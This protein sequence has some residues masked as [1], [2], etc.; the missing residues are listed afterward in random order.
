MKTLSAI[1]CA[2]AFLLS[3]GCQGI[4]PFSTSSAAP[5]PS[6][7]PAPKFEL[8]LGPPDTSFKS[9]FGFVDQRSNTQVWIKADIY[10]VLLRDSKAK[11]IDWTKKQDQGKALSSVPVSGLVAVESG[12]QAKSF[13]IDA[14][15]AKKGL[16]DYL[17]QQGATSLANSSTVYTI[18]GMIAPIST[19]D[20]TG[21]LVALTCST[22]GR[23]ITPGRRE[24]SFNFAV[25]PKVVN[26]SKVFI[27]ATAAQSLSASE[28][29][30]CD[31]KNEP[32]DLVQL[33]KSVVYGSSFYLG[34]K[35]ALVISGIHDSETDN[36]NT[37][38]VMVLTAGIVKPE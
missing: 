33:R 16:S 5:T 20:A 7:V 32:K 19:I 3:S 17:V 31:E 9:E 4:H 11:D 27:I 1:L 29:S 26:D 23:T 25:T 10:K 22:D 8:P 14:E 13:K 37:V 2:S 35:Q 21:Y 24:S 38:K 36:D 34:N 15:F 30:D 6:E 28:P 18:D 12:S